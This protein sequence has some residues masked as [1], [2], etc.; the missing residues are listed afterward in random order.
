MTVEHQRDSYRS[1]AQAAADAG[2]GI[3]K[4]LQERSHAWI[5]LLVGDKTE[6]IR[7][8]RG[9]WNNW[10][11]PGDEWNKLEQKISDTDSY[12]MQRK[13]EREEKQPLFGSKHGKC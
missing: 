2:A 3:K 5:P 4:S 1:Y 10:V 8:L 7:T 6:L 11:E 12:K 13:E 9:Y